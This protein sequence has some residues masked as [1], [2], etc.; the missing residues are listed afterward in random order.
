MCACVYARACVRAHIVSRQTGRQADRQTDRKADR[1]AGTQTRRRADIE[2]TEACVCE[3]GGGVER[4]TRWLGAKAIAETPFE[5]SVSFLA[6]TN[7]ILSGPCCPRPPTWMRVSTCERGARAGAFV[8][9]Q[10]RV[11]LFGQSACGR[12]RARTRDLLLL[13]DDDSAVI[14]AGGQHLPEFRVRP[15]DFPDRRTVACAWRASGSER[16]AAAGSGQRRRSARGHRRPRFRVERRQAGARARQAGARAG[17]HGPR[18]AGGMGTKRLADRMPVAVVV[19]FEYLDALPPSP[20]RRSARTQARRHTWSSARPRSARARAMPHTRDAAHQPSGLASARART[21]SA[22]RGRAHR[23]HLV[24]GAG[25]H[26]LAVVVVRNVVDAR[27]VARRHLGRRLQRRRGHRRPRPGAVRRTAAGR[28]AVFG[29]P[30]AAQ[31]HSGLAALR[32]C[33]SSC[34]DGFHGDGFVRFG[35]NSKIFEAPS[36]RCRRRGA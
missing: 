36:S 22:P 33:R 7:W 31:L 28:G 23:A 29:A 1:Q 30:P 2:K 14:G 34:S 11:F 8:C 16:G 19:C 3:R 6:S 17:A 12:E 5:K 25:R 15:V 21:R 24:A 32:P 9:A 18:G 13:P 27:L 10:R 20:R 4:G 26:A 35:A